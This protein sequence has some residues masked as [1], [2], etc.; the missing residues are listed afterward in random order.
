MAAHIPRATKQCPFTCGNCAILK[1]LFFF[2]ATAA[3]A[4]TAPCTTPDP[5]E[6]CSKHTQDTCDLQ[7]AVRYYCP[8][9][10]RKCSS[11]IMPGGQPILPT[12]LAS[13]V[14]KSVPPRQFPAGTV[15][16]QL[17]TPNRTPTRHNS[18]VMLTCNSYRSNTTS[19]TPKGCV[20]VER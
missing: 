14:V 2:L 7:P 17:S 4:P 12:T 6:L 8:W 1:S 10:C 16:Q 11:A 15:L 13:T 5:P 3:A 19:R 9:L 20:G 18:V